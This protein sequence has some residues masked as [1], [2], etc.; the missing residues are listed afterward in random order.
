MIKADIDR[1]HL[2][3]EVEGK[4]EEVLTELTILILKVAEEIIIGDDTD[5]INEF[6]QM[7]SEGVI[8]T[9]KLN[10]K[11]GKYGKHMDY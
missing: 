8:Y 11:G 7:L 1:R 3:L 5:D 4:S 2:E 6:M 10:K 9:S